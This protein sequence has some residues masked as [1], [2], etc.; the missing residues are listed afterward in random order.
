MSVLEKRALDSFPRVIS[1]F[2]GK[3][4]SLDYEEQVKKLLEIFRTLAA[5]KSVKIHFLSLHLDYFSDNCGDYSE[6]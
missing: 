6:E 2:L 5:Q 4:R 1:N 3:Y